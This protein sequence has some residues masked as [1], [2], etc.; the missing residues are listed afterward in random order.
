MSNNSGFTSAYIDS[1]SNKL[2][3]IANSVSTVADNI[4]AGSGIGGIG[5]SNSNASPAAIIRQNNTYKKAFQEAKDTM[6]KAPL[7]LSLAEKNYYLYNDGKA[8]GANIY[9]KL[10]MDRFA[11]SAQEFRVNSI[12]MQQQFMA[13][14]SQALKQYQAQTLFLA[15]SKK[16]LKTRKAEHEALIKKINYYQ[17]IVQTSERKVV[18]E[19]KNMDTLY[20]YRRLMIFVYY[21]AMIIFI[22]FGN[23]IPDKLYLKSSVWLILVIV[24]II[25]LILNIGIKWLFM[26]YETLSY[27]FGDIGGSVNTHLEGPPS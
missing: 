15:Q 25:P 13:D 17:K 11:K 7:D 18:Y 21:A 4:G 2:G 3:N 12:E 16:L 9:N 10:I 8:G 1:I 14:L 27:W 24:S 6:G 23:F 19:N 22:L 26:I 20:T 5:G